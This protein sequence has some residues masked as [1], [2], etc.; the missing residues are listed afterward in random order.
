MSSKETMR[1]KLHAK[2][3]QKQ[4]GRMSTVQRTQEVDKYCKKL[5]VSEKDMKDIV[6]LS[7]KMKNNKT[8]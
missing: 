6:E 4:L 1:E 2:I 8:K 7:E 5:G 3:K